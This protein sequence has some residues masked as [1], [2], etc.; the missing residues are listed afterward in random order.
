[1]SGL[2]GTLIVILAFCV[3]AVVSSAGGGHSGHTHTGHQAGHHHHR[4]GV[5]NLM[6]ESFKN[7]HSR[8]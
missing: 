8:L 1:M 6:G 4:G 7:L 3:M 5:T 2:M